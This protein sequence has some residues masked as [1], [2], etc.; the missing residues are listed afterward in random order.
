V[1]AGLSLTNE[2]TTGRE[3]RSEIRENIYLRDKGKED[4]A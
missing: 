3:E 1:I 4:K 2:E